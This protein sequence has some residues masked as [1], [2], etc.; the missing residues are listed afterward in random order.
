[1]DNDRDFLKLD[2]YTSIHEN[3]LNLHELS[4]FQRIMLVNDGTL[5]DIVEAYLFEQLCV[6]KLSEQISP[7]TRMIPAL[8]LDSPS[9]IIERRV[10]LQGKESKRNWLYA[11]SIIVPARLD[12]PFRKALLK[13]QASI[14]KLWV[15]HRMETFKEILTLYW[16][17]AGEL[18]D[19]F[20]IE[21]EN[22][23]LCRTYRVFFKQQPIMLITEKFPALFF[24]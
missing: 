20:E 2:L 21:K 10:L 22:R 24:R 12:A 14:G 3:S 9:E 6:V 16:E 5:T 13:S 8:M 11:E 4:I 18:A 19:F 15:I 17:T 23:L 1:M 7:T